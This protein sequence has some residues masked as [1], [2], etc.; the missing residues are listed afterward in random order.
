MPKSKL[1]KKYFPLIRQQIK[2]VYFDNAA[3]TQKPET[4]LRAMDKFYRQHY[5]SVHRGIY[6]LS[7]QATQAYEAAREKI[8]KFLRARHPEEIIFTS[9]ATE[10]INLVASS[11]AGKF[12]KRGDEILISEL[13]HHSNIVPW[14]VAAEK[15]RLILKFVPVDKQGVLDAKALNKLLTNRVKLIAITAASNVT[16]E[17]VDLKKIIAA[18]HK[19]GAKVLVD[20]AQAAGHF[21][22]N[23]QKLD[24][25]FLVFSGH[26][27]FGPT[28]IGVLFGKKEL[29]EKMPPFHT[30]GNMIELVT[31]NKTTFAP[32][33][34][35][36]EA[37][38]P[39]IAEVI[40]L[41][42]AV[43]FIQ[44][45]GW[46]KIQSA[47]NA[48]A[49]YTLQKLAAVPGVNILGSRSANGRL[50]IFS[51]TVDGIHPHDLATMLDRYGI[52][53][54]AGHHCAQILHATLGTPAST[55][56]SL[57]FYNTPDEIDILVRT[58]VKTIYN[59]RIAN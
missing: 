56:V 31:K 53:V 21:P 39:P 11:F 20:A 57:G 8:Q 58:L 9:G 48:L 10:G 44:Q 27:M 45:I 7:E 28:G 25:D 14:Q 43:D 13:E 36:F 35:K 32:I 19:A 30:G 54:R 4:V 42:A 52:A 29:L 17:I 3:T 2:L 46:Q 47:E 23:A 16:G 12:L 24:C 18:A 40:G 34:T 51:F 15:H 38:T 50:P 33:P 41:G 49:K 37:G 26:K 6:R 5:S 55:R 59:F 22:L 1:F